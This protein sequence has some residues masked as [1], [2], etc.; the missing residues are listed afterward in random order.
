MN[1]IYSNREALMDN[2]KNM[3]KINILSKNNLGIEI[4]LNN[5]K[6]IFSTKKNENNIYPIIDKINISSNAYQKGL[7]TGHKLITLNGYSLLNKDLATI[8]SDF[9]YAKRANTYLE[10]EYL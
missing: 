10:I 2:N 6:T 1:K 8:M 4:K 5:Q 7:R 3:K 9:D